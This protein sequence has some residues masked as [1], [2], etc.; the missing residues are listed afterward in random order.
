MGLCV[1]FSL[2][3]YSGGC[4]SGACCEGL[5]QSSELWG[6]EGDLGGREEVICVF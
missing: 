1:G 4:L 3:G 6:R 5:K 2:W